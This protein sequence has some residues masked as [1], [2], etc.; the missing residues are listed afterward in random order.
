MEIMPYEAAEE[1][2]R[3]QSKIVVSPCICRKEHA[4]AGHGC[5]NPLEVCLVFGSGA[6]YYE[7]NGLGRSITTE[8]ALEVLSR[9]MDAGLVLQPGNS[10][11]AMNICMCCG[12]CCQVL[13]NLKTLDAP[14]RAVNANYFASVDET[15]CV[16]CG[17]CADR[18]HME[19]IL[20]DGVAAIDPDRC[21]G[22][23][24]CVPTCDAEALTLNPKPEARRT[25]PPNTVFDTY[26]NIARERGLFDEKQ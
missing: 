6:Y 16:G 4:M 14:A 20:V 18:C 22:C 10:K 3:K 7:E 9:G 12:C 21:I 25:E 1:I 11:K 19:A 13:K 17:V 23:G 8:A 5:D 24:V 2:I 15:V 26:F